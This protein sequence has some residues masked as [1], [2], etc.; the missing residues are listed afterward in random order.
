MSDQSDN[1]EGD[2]G[3]GAYYYTS[4]TQS[5]NFVLTIGSGSW[6]RMSGGV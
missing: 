2:G 6:N 4:S 1:S 5:D 3:D